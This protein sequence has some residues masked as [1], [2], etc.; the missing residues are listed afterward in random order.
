[1]SQHHVTNEALAEKVGANGTTIWRICMVGQLPNIALALKIERWAD[2]VAED[3][4]LPEP[5]RFSW[6]YVLDDDEAA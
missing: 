4:G 2:R 5:R 3:L 1:M 6:D